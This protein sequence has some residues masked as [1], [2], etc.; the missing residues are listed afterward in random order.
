MDV[1]ISKDITEDDIR[2]VFGGTI[3]DCHPPSFINAKLR[4]EQAFVAKENGKPVGFLLYSIWW[5]NCPFIEYVKIK[6]PQQRRRVGLKLLQAAAQDIQAQNFKELISS[7]EVVND[8]GNNFHTKWGFKKLN[9]LPLPHG[10]EQFYKVDL[11]NLI[12]EVA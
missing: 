2:N 4:D 10:E 6:E 8:I 1:T 3:P 7:S 12:K 5:G 11:A 9:T